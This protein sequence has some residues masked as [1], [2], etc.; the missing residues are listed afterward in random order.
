VNRSPINTIPPISAEEMKAR[1]IDGLD[2]VT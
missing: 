2:F 1:G